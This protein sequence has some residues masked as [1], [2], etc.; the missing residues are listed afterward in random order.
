MQGSRTNNPAPLRFKGVKMKNYITEI[1]PTSDLVVEA[2]AK[3]VFP[4]ST[5]FRARALKLETPT[6]NK[7]IYKKTLIEREVNRLM[8]SPTSIFGAAYHPKNGSAEVPDVSHL[9]T[10]LEVG[11]DGYLWCEG[12]ILDTAKGR[13]LKAIISAGKIG[14][15]LRGSGKVDEK[16]G[17][18]DEETYRLHSIDAVLSPASEGAHL[19][20]ENVF[21]SVAFETEPVS[22][23][24][25]EQQRI[26]E[27]HELAE[28]I[29]EQARESGTVLPKKKFLE[30][31]TAMKA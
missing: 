14:L 8:S 22:A 31:A 16:T 12:E 19:S 17:V 1:E 15:S 5:K 30:I 29:E 21:E 25:L 24:N 2:K 13:D 6:A 18:V 23:S 11:Q 28:R 9:I 7:R 20:K 26:A 4:Q 3:T 27:I 10:K